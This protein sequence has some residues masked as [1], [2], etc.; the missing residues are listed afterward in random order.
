[1]RPVTIFLSRLLGLSMLV[2]SLAMVLH[3]QA[4]AE[5][6]SMAVHD[7]PLL[8]ILGL[9]TLIAGLAMVLAHN[10]WSGGSLPVVV[11]LIGWI[12][13]IRG[14]ILLLAPPDALASLFEM[15][16]SEKFF[17]VPAAITFALGLYLT[18]MGF[19]PSR[20]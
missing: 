9:I 10:I 15:I 12:T 18:Y 11:T 1:M 7:R 19:R 5:T 8:F 20:V 6:A 16:D 14:L 4:I 2:L 3:R 17:S 13:L